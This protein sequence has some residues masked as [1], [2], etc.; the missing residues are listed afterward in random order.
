MDRGQKR[1]VPLL[2]KVEGCAPVKK[3]LLLVLIGAGVFAVWKKVQADRAELD[4]WTEATT[5]DA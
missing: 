1:P 3:L 2:A 5:D 4:L